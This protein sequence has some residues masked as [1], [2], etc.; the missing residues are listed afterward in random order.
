MLFLSIKISSKSVLLNV[1]DRK[2]SIE[3]IKYFYFRLRF[4]ECR[5]NRISFKRR[6]KTIYQIQ[7][8]GILPLRSYCSIAMVIRPQKIADYTC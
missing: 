1:E 6:F 3:W 7:L 2:T 8:H 4:L 5:L